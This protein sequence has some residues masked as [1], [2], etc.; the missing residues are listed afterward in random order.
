MGCEGL[1]WVVNEGVRVGAGS[2]ETGTKAAPLATTAE[3]CVGRWIACTDLCC[4]VLCCRQPPG[5]R[6]LQ[7]PVVSPGYWGHI[8]AVCT[9]QWGC[10]W[11]CGWTRCGDKV[12]VSSA[13][14]SVQ[15][16]L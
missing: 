7:Q 12:Q 9:A 5:D 8:P 6:Q 2:K 15:C 1:A 3:W 16:D 14:G 11:L 10:G 13:V 4:V